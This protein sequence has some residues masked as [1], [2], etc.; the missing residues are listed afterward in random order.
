LLAS[1]PGQAQDSIDLF[2]YEP[3]IEW[4]DA[5]AIA[6]RLLRVSKSATTDADNA[7][8]ISCLEK[9]AQHAPSAATISVSIHLRM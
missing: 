9:P 3:A 4:C 5:E 8:A 7:A 6:V 1:P 2:H